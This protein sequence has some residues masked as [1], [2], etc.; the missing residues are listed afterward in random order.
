MYVFRKKNSIKSKCSLEVCKK[1]IDVHLTSVEIQKK[2]QKI[3]CYN[4]NKSVERQRKT[5]CPRSASL[6]LATD[7][8]I[9][10]SRIN[11]ISDFFKAIIYNLYYFLTS[12]SDS[13]WEE[14]S[15]SYE[16]KPTNFPSTKGFSVPRFVKTD[17][18]HLHR[19]FKCW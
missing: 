8:T 3:I 7:L 18:V 10:K 19:I 11:Y 6:T 1:M 13:N 14:Y 16:I 9:S 2:I 12:D 17:N 15:A 4:G 5:R